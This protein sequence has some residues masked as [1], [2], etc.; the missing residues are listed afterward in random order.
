M[1]TKVAGNAGG[2]P[3]KGRVQAGRAASVRLRLTSVRAPSAATSTSN[4][5]VDAPGIAIA[6]LSAA[7]AEASLESPL[8]A[9]PS[10][11]RT[12]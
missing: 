4:A 2:A 11:A 7:V 5:Q 12:T 1:S 9:V 10:K 6:A 3:T 8:S